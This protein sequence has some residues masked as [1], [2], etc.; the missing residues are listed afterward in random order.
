MKRA[1]Y[2]RLFL[3]LAV[4][5]LPSVGIVVQSRRIA[6]DDIEKR[7]SAQRERIA[8][9]QESAA[10]EIGQDMFARLEVVKF[11]EIASSQT[12]SL[13]NGTYSD[14]AVVLVGWTEGDQLVWPWDAE[15]V[16]NQ[17][18]PIKEDTDFAQGLEDA[19]RAEF[20]ASDQAADL[21][22]ALIER[23]H[24]D[25]QRAIARLALAQ[26]LVRSNAPEDARKEYLELLSLP[27]NLTDEFGY[28]F[29]SYAA[30]RLAKAGRGRDAV[31]GVKRALAQSVSSL[32]QA[33]R[34][35]SILKTLENSEDRE[36]RDYVQPALNRVSAYVTNLE[37]LS[38]MKEARDLQILFP[39]L[40]VTATHWKPYPGPNG[41]L[42]LIGR[43][44]DGSGPRPL[45]LAVRAEAIRA[46][47]E[48]DR[49]SRGVG[50]PFRIAVGGSEGKP[51][52]D[53]LTE[54]RVI[55]APGAAPGGVPTGSSSAPL[56]SLWLLF[57]V[58]LTFLGGY[59][60]WR[61][62]RR[63]IRVAEMRA[64][65]VSSVSHE[66]KTPLTSIRMFAESLQIDSSDPK[67]NEEYLA[68]IVNESERLTR[69][70]NN[71]L[72]FS[73]IE[74]GQRAYA[75]RPTPLQEVVDAVTR[76]MEYP[77][78]EKGF[79]LNI[80]VNDGIPPVAADRDALEQ[81]ILNLLTNAMKYSGKR[82][83]I[84]LRV[85]SENGSAWIQ[86]TDHGIGI[87][88]KEQTRIFEKFYRAHVPENRSIAG[89]GLGLAMVAHIAEGHGG[90][91]QVK[92][93]PGE[94]STFSLRLPLN[95]SKRHEYD[96][97][98]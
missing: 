24:N 2:W 31:E 34:L 66:L 1:R 33:Y 16:D 77:L 17:A 69:L 90:S 3:F 75:L 51:L 68:T 12:T 81:A 98:D 56:Y 71:V 83:D 26:T 64:G 11:R 48:S 25:R 89:T 86:V 9:E 93:S 42:W 19:R 73:R 44:P 15:S 57:V 30:T 60:L 45:V 23:A 36:V 8:A 4:L 20:S 84:D 18:V 65:F 80:N 21:Y 10:A 54:L 27:W 61:D 74:R 88:A 70:L 49:L 6:L 87:P 85:L 43:A 72:D 79:V 14:P 55:L 47:V 91:V 40:G 53:R 82:R 95:G 50:N 59:L 97:G 37:M 63:E 41:D 22:R 7:T 32:H 13:Q 28:S 78:Q 92:S 29:S 76:T 96:S 39:G 5:I 52:G 58:P 67:T 35:R 94:G 62:M 38:Q 46:S